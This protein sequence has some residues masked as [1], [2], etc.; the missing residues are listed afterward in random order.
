VDRDLVCEQ[1]DPGEAQS[2]Q[3]EHSFLACSV[4]CQGLVKK[5]WELCKK[6]ALGKKLDIQQQVARSA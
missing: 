5:K 3:G 1:G 6:Q 2:S 4:A